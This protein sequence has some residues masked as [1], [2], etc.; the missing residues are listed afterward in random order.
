MKVPHTDETRL[1]YIAGP[2]R[3]FPDF[4]YP[5]FNAVEEELTR[6]GWHVENPVKIGEEFGTPEEINSNPELLLSVM[7]A[8]LATVKTCDAVFLLRGW[9]R[10]VGA[11]KELAAALESGAEI[12]LEENDAPAYD[13][14]LVGYIRSTLND[15][16][17]RWSRAE[18]KFKRTDGA[19]QLAL[20]E[21]DEARAVVEKLGAEMS[22]AKKYIEGAKK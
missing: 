1:I 4:N 22:A 13:P 16:F 19:L 11:K 5:K 12:Y 14:D 7:N 2:M 20:K 10:S 17:D 21:N 8:E 15:A 6:N 9:E 18:D 3:G